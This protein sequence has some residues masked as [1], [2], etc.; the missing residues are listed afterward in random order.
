MASRSRRGGDTAALPAALVPKD[1]LPSGWGDTKVGPVCPH[2][3]GERRGAASRSRRGEDTAA[4]PPSLALKDGLPSGWRGHQGR[5]GVSSHRRGVAW[6][7]SRSRRGEG[8]AAHQL[9]YSDAISADRY[10]LLLQLLLT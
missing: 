8:T 10:A 5:A 6:P 9:F 1:R 7:A 3:A 4:L 2:T